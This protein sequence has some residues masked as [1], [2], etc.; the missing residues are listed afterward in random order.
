MSTV[1]SR[2][3]QS[4]DLPSNHDSD[5]SSLRQAI[6]VNDALVHGQANQSWKYTSWAPSIQNTGRAPILKAPT[7]SMI[8][9]WVHGSSIRHTEFAD[10]F[11]TVTSP[12]SQT[13]MTATIT[14][15]DTHTI[16]WNEYL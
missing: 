3:R 11:V 13:L 4:C 8:V 12:M 14:A 10:R 7:S 2:A 1:L 6:I 5:L 15:V 9:L 16:K